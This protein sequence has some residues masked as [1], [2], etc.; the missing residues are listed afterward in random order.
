MNFKTHEIL[1]TLIACICIVILTRPAVH[2]PTEELPIVEVSTMEAFNRSAGAIFDKD[3]EA[4]MLSFGDAITENIRPEMQ[5]KLA[6][7]VAAIRYAE[8]GTTYQ[9][10]ILHDRCPATYRGQAS[11]CAATVQKT[12]DRY[13]IA[14][15]DPTDINAFII[16]L[17]ARYCPIGVANDPTGLNVNWVR[18]VTS[19][20]T[21]ILS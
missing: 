16:H 4:A 9:Y 17:G 1:I 21:S 5:A 3:G 12:W 13:I 8:N 2:E 19:I 18:N 10:G 20:Y 11:W 7:I 6:P 15:G 14:D